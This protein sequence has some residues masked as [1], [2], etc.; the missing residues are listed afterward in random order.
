MDDP[1]EPAAAIEARAVRVAYGATVALRGVDLAVPWGARLA[2]LGPNGAGKS[3]LLRVLATLARPTGGEVRLGG[4]DPARDPFAARRLIGVV[5]HQTYLYDDLT[6][7]E[8]L[9]FYAALYGLRDPAGRA[10]ELLD[11]VGLA[12]KRD[13]RARALSRGQQQRLTIA[14]ALLHDPPIL[15]LDEP[16]TGLDLTAFGLLERLLL[17]RPGGRT[18]VLATHNLRLAARLCDSFAILDAGR[19]AHVATSDGPEQREGRATSGEREAALEDIYRRA[20]SDE[21]RAGNKAGASGVPGGTDPAAH[22]MSPPVAV[23]SLVAR[24]S[25]LHT[26]WALAR[27][28]LLIELRSRDVLSTAVVFTLLVLLIFNFALDLAGETVPAVAPGVLWVT[29]IFAGMLTLGRTMARERERDA[30]QGLLVAPLDRGGLFAGKLVA[31]LVL[32]GVVEL[33][34]LPVFAALYRLTFAP[35]PLLLA[36]LLGTLGFASVGTLFAAVAANT[37]AREA[38]LPLLLFPVLVPV[39]IGAVQATAQTIVGAPGGGPPWL[40]LLAAFDAI[41]LT[42]GYV[43]FEYVVEE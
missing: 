34:A 43:V 29:F 12:T 27:K 2:L 36:T 20:T 24:R 13:A 38:L 18:I 32:L 35:G 15:L 39:V 6:A 41:F 10:A 30:L 25:S 17:D 33:V 5:A 9:R 40:G 7:L 8:N 14:R 19:L 11:A 26:A 1:A 3:T 42:L 37:R 31:N 22:A 4:C 21:R 16:D 23:S 28:D